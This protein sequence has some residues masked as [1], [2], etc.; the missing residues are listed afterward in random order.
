MNL[1]QDGK[2]EEGLETVCDVLNELSR[3]KTGSVTCRGIL[4]NECPFNGIGGLKRWIN[5]AKKA[6]G[7]K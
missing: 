5:E 2:L 3:E 7:R 1:I 4:C 6:G